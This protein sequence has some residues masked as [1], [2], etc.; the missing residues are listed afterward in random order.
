ML[1]QI[2]VNG[3]L[4]THHARSLLVRRKGKWVRPNAADIAGMA[5]SNAPATPTKHVAK[6]Q[7]QRTGRACR[8]KK[9]VP[10]GNP[11][12]NTSRTRF[13]IGIGEFHRYIKYLGDGVA[14][15]SRKSP[16]I[17]IGRPDSKRSK[18]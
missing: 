12:L 15:P 9:L 5:Q 10:S 6:T 4:E 13:Q 11:A 17:Y 3:H 1:V 8:R 7:R 2:E 14:P 16:L 18:H